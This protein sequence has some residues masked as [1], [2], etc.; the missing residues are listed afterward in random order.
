MD[1][2]GYFWFPQ[3]ESKL[4]T[5]VIAN[6]IEVFCQLFGLKT[7]NQI[8]SSPLSSATSDLFKLFFKSDNSD[9]PLLDFLTKNNKPIYVLG[10]LSSEKAVE[11]SWRYLGLNIFELPWCNENQ[12]KKVFR[13]IPIVSLVKHLDELK[14]FFDD[15]QL[16]ST[17]CNDFR[18]Q[19]QW[20]KCHQFVRE[21]QMAVGHGERSRFQSMTCQE[22]KE[23]LEK[24]ATGKVFKNLPCGN[25][26]HLKKKKESLIKEMNAWTDKN[27]KC[28]ELARDV[29]NLDCRAYRLAQAKYAPQIS[30]DGDLKFK[31]IVVID[32]NN[33]FLNELVLELEKIV[34]DKQH[35]VKADIQKSWE[36][37]RLCDEQGNDILNKWIY[38]DQIEPTQ[39][40]ACCDLDIGPKSDMNEL[41]ETFGGHWIMYGTALA[42]PKVPRLVVTGFRSQDVQGFAAG[43][44]AYLLKPFTQARL[45]SQIIKA[46]ARRCVKWLC[47]KNIQEEYSALLPKI[48]FYDY[49]CFLTKW[50][51]KQ[52]IELEVIEKIKSEIA[53]ADLV[54]ID[55]K[56]NDSIK[57]LY[58]IRELNDHAALSLIFPF[59]LDLENTLFDYYR[60]LP[61]SFRAGI[62]TIIKKPMWLVA[63]G[64]PDDKDALGNMIVQQLDSLDNDFDIKYQVLVPVAPIIGRCD[65][66]FIY[67]LLQDKRRIT[68]DADLV[69]A[70]LLP[71]LVDAY[72]MSARLK[73]VAKLGTKLAKVL[74]NA[75]FQARDKDLNRWKGIEDNQIIDVIFNFT[76]T[77]GDELIQRHLNLETWLHYVVDNKTKEIFKSTDIHTLT[78]P[79]A[80]VFGGSTRY[81]FVVRGSWYKSIDQRIDDMLISVEFCAKSS[82]MAKQFIEET[83]VKY[84]GKIAGE[85]L[86][87]VQ[88]IPFRG[89]LR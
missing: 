71:F 27:E 87:F 3:I 54:L 44:S 74:K 64:C 39:I 18:D 29:S 26:C 66:N 81:E 24:A 40:L 43:A 83:V 55:V 13:Y 47:P 82:L 56:F 61:L 34:V 20:A 36:S 16:I 1:D 15:K 78:A 37:F 22:I 10:T 21:I 62:D 19:I 6:A 51:R 28:L 75:I 31:R 25:E 77:I 72:G 48:S 84:L 70:P 42:Y 68:E 65:G 30:D 57:T 33:E 60:Q 50:L 46:T 49:K 8:V 85:D 76:F 17:S 58:K 38:E 2:D 59:D 7:K 9:G 53:E 80:R 4:E 73:D 69:F 67:E 12:E 86:V 11:H 41:I 14:T 23:G 79:L 89:Y 88:E 35:I 63:D 52:G 5:A 45:E 32:D